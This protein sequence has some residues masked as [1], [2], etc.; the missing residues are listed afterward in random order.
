M[1][2][3]RTMPQKTEPP[4]KVVGFHVEGAS[5]SPR[6][7]SLREA[8]KPASLSP[9]IIPP[10]FQVRSGVLRIPEILPIPF[11]GGSNSCFLVR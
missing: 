1:D 6:P 10:S 8:V 9:V 7:S 11:D 2:H 5:P 3:G 4:L